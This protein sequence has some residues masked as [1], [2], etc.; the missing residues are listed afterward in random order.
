MRAIQRA[1]I[2]V[3][4][5]TSCF[6]QDTARMDQVVQTYVQ[7]K[8]FMGTVLVARGADVILSKGYGSANFEWDIS[9]TP[10]TKFRLGSLTKQFT[11]ASILLLEERGR[12]TI[13]DPIRKYLADAPAAWDRITIYHL[14]THTSGIPNFTSLPDYPTL[15]RFDSP[16]AKTIATFRDK[17]LDFQPGEKMS[18]SNSGYLV[19]GH[20]IETLTGGSYEKFVT[21]NIFTPLGMKDSGY[22]S[23]TTIIGHRAAGYMPSANGPVNA[24]FIHMSIPHAAGALYSTTEDLLRWEQ[25]LFGGKVI[26]PA[27]LAKMTTPFKNDYALGVV[28]Q[29]ASGRRVVQHAGGIDG[30]NTYLAYYPDSK[31]TVAVLANINGQTPNEIATKLADLAHGSA[32]QLTSERKAITLPVATLSKYVGTYEVAPRV[33]MMIR[34]DGDHLTTQLASQPQFPI[35]AESETR[36]FLKVVDAQLEFLMDERGAVTHAILHQNGRDLK[37]PRTRAT[38]APPP[39]HNEIAVPASTLARYVGTYQMRPNVEMSITLDGDHLTAQL[40]GQP[41]FPIFAES[42][43]LF[44]FRIVEATLDFQKDAGGAVTAVRLRQ[45]PINELGPRK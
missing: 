31:L 36:F 28:V 17:P 14:L 23:N 8:T 29:T 18:Y 26:S 38:A 4:L 41:A 20:L 16:V 10:S 35:F 5:A 2:V 13:E 30:F 40:T 32:V 12:L 22:D 42:E 6:A 43:T 15:Q 21:D 1:I 11:A 24:G 7:N 27:S 19:L 44:F 25:G 33:E 45:G 9:N 39:Q 34:L 37:A 3:F